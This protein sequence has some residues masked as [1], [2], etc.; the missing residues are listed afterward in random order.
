MYFKNSLGIKPEPIDKEK[1]S[2]LERNKVYSVCCRC[3]KKR[4]S[5]RAMETICSSCEQAILC[6]IQIEPERLIEL[7]KIKTKDDIHHKNNGQ[8]AA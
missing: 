4:E 1:G 6:T 3:G 7:Q 2:I 5:K 8:S